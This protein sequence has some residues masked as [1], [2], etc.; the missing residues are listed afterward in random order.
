MLEIEYNVDDGGEREARIVT[1][2]RDES[3]M[4]YV[5]ACRPPVCIGGPRVSFPS[6]RS[7]GHAGTYVG[8]YGLQYAAAYARLTG[9]KVTKT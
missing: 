3:R 6:L 9:L 4:N 7:K 8:S 5:I 1:Y 2:G